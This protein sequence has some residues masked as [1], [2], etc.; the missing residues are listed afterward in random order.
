MKLLVDALLDVN[1]VSPHL[2]ITSV[3]SNDLSY[4]P[5]LKNFWPEEP[6]N[7]NLL[8][9]PLILTPNMQLKSSNF[10]QRQFGERVAMNSP[11][12]GTAADIMKI[13]MIAVDRELRRRGLKSR[14]VL[15][16]HDEL[17]VETAKDEA[18]EVKALLVDK[19]KHAADL[20]VALEVEAQEGDSWFDAK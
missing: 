15:Q 1:S 13:A 9:E 16:I 4:S 5:L 6:N 11:I 18:E 3:I 17:L 2:I 14:I 7:L 20:K 10:L 8:I 12:Q 19:M